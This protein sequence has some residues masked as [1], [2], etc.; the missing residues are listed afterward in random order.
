[1]EK[2]LS[3]GD[4]IPF[5]ILQILSSKPVWLVIEVIYLKPSLKGLL[6]PVGKQEF[7]MS[8]KLFEKGLVDRDGKPTKSN[9]MRVKMKKDSWWVGSEIV[10][11][12]PRLLNRII[13]RFSVWRVREVVLSSDL[14]NFRVDAMGD[15]LMAGVRGL[16]FTI[17]FVKDNYFGLWDMDWFQFTWKNRECPGD[18]WNQKDTRFMILALEG[19]ALLCALRVIKKI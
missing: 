15:S 1:M 6:R 14:T 19:L 5:L 2:S 12:D 10:I 11:D 16:V 17:P 8:K 18:L 13:K 9:V 3:S 4:K 7:T